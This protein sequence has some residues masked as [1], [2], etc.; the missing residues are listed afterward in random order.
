[1]QLE[2]KELKKNV[3]FENQELN[4]LKEV[5]MSCKSG[6]IVSIVGESGSGKSTLLNILSLLDDC[7]SGEYYW[8][9][10]NIFML[11]RR[12]KQELLVK[13]IGI[14]FQQYNLINTM[15]C[16]E[17]VKAPLYLNYDVK[18][19]EREQTVN[20]ILER[21]GLSERKNHYPKTLSGGE[22]QR[23]A[24]ARALINNPEVI[25]ADEPT[26]N[27]DSENEKQI[28]NIFR[29][30]S[31]QGKIVVIVTHSEVVKAFSDKIYRI[32]DGVVSKEGYR[33]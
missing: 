6:E 10:K 30:I 27:V 32:S 22:Q 18:R 11:D 2:V 17:N 33:K 4:I 5:N 31:N 12:E 7:T 8:N 23:V 19:Q 21:V 28:L 20:A 26:G 25:F 3:L 29:E 16:F 14:V 13:K 24:I 1:M 15:T 9:D